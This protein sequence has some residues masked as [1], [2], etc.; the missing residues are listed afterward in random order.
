V[1]E[2]GRDRFAE[3]V[4]E[5]LADLPPDVARHL[6]N[7][8]VVVED[9]GEDPELLGLYEG[10]PLTERS[11]DYSAV[12]PDRIVIYRLPICAMCESENEVV[13]EVRITV[14]HEIGHHFGISDE[15]LHE[16]G[17]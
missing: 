7:V 17:W 14:V 9:G 15:R 6:S 11:S 10:I 8:G 5:A 12:L 3:L 16:L 2:I 4:D 13:D 1:F